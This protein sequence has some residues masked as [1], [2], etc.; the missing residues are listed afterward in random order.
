MMILIR[1]PALVVGAL[2][3]RCIVHTRLALCD[4][5]AWIPAD[6]R[7]YEREPE[8]CRES[9]GVRLISL[10]RIA[11]KIADELPSAVECIRRSIR[12]PS[13]S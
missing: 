6:R 5:R 8:K 13:R 2:V 9:L 1:I 4:L 3:R 12:I 11:L 10:T 7:L